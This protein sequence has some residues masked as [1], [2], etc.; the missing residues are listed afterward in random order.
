M[1]LLKTTGVTRKIDELGRIVIPKEIRRNLGIRDGES[2]EIFIDSDAIILKKHS[3]LHNY[4][5][6]GSK[7]CDIISSIING[8]VIICDREKVIA[9]DENN[10]EI[11]AKNN[12]KFLLNLI[13]NRE[14]YVSNE[15]DELK[16]EDNII[17]GYF[18][19]VPV[20]SS[21]DSLGLV[22]IVS[23]QKKDYIN[24]AKVIGKI[25]SEKLDIC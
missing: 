21:I 6:I 11:I 4:E 15:N 23:E 18:S 19:I 3:Q 7:L 25:F 5:E 13:D 22:V 16:F 20:I 9:V 2:L 1:K 12:D 14:S 24:I 8:S 10:K 17:S